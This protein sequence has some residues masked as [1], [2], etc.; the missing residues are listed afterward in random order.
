MAARIV[1]LLTG[2]LLSAAS[3]H[4]ASA[5]VV[6][7]K[8]NGI[9]VFGECIVKVTQ[10]RGSVTV[11]NTVVAKS[12][13]EASEQAVRAHEALRAEVKKLQLKDSTAETAGYTVEEE[14]SYPQGGKVCSGYRARLATQFESSEI[15]RIGEVIAVASKMGSE[16][17]SDLRTLVSPQLMQH[18]RE[19]CLEVATRNAMAKAQKIATGA[20]VRLGRLISISEAGGGEP[21][22][23]R[24][25]RAVAM[26]DR[27]VD[28]AAPTIE[29]KPEDVRV[30]VSAVYAIE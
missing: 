27:M 30:V 1:Y 10:D 21:P 4:P 2:L 17:V 26:A 16:E 11:A 18:E 29:A 12:A 3:V 15:G 24:F 22:S 6:D 25:T 9:S 20:G 28:S 7:A 8:Q 13:K 14:C 23:V 5:Q 19:G